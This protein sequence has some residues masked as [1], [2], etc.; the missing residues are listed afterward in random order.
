MK[1]IYSKTIE[2]SCGFIFARWSAGA[3][4][5]EYTLPPEQRVIEDPLA[6]YYA[7]EIGMK[8]VGW[9]QAINPSIRKAI[10][11]RARYMDDYARECLNQ[12]FQQVVL[13]GA[14]Y[15]SRFLRLS[16]FKE[17]KIFELD[18]NSTQ[19]IKKTLTRRILGKLPENVTYV[20][21]D[22]SKDSIIDKLTKAGFKQHKKTLFIWE[23]VTL[24]LNQ[25]IVEETLGRL[26]ELGRGNRLV[27]DF[28]PPELIDDETDYQ[29]NR[30]LLK[31]C[32]SVQEPLTFGCSPEKM[33]G[34]LHRLGYG[35][36]KIVSMQETNWM[37]SESDQIENS[38]F[39]ATAEVNGN[40]GSE[41]PFAKQGNLYL[42]AKQEKVLETVS[43]Q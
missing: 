21:I 18:L 39:F 20:S 40:P 4:A 13:L 2:K 38:Y 33:R 27:V 19:V 25:D 10:V 8:V 3:K 24:F 9:M 28:I 41:R 1:A 35:N 17:A 32:A 6:K 5:F 29:G 43:L 34:I 12:G 30:E 15:D 23:A 31:L 16:E 14:G 42:P 36:I 11:L 22:F 26:A 37:Y 7:G